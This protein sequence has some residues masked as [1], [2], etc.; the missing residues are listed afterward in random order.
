MKKILFSVAAFSMLLVSC[1]KD[2]NSSKVSHIPSTSSNNT[3]AS[4]FVD[5]EYIIQL[6]SGFFKTTGI[7]GS[8]AEYVSKIQKARKSLNNILLALP[9]GES[10]EVLNVYTTAINGFAAKLTDEQL[11]ALSTL[12][13]VIAI[14][15]NQ[16]GQL[17]G[18]AGNAEVQSQTEEYGVIRTGRRDGTGKRAFILDSGID[19]DHEDLNV[20]TDLGKDFTADGGLF[21]GGGGL[22]GGG[23][24]GGGLFG[25]GGEAGPEGDDDNGHGTHCAGIVAAL[26]NNVGVVG[27]APN[28]EV[29]AVKCFN[30]LGNGNS[31]DVIQ[32]IDYVAE[33]GEAGDAV[34]MSF[35]FLSSS[36]S[37]DNAVESLGTQGLYVAIAAGNDSRDATGVSPAGANGV[38]LYTVSAMDVNDVFASFSNYGSPV[39]YSAPGVDVY[40][41]YT[42]NGYSTLSGT[43]MA[44][45]HVAGLLLI[46]DGD[47]N[48]DGNVIGDPDGDADPIAHL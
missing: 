27:V 42:N 24:F 43:S 38:N 47:L 40:S 39:D 21:G 33:V 16:V 8:V 32:A 14:D 23:L 45:P 22:F 11:Q 34:N 6:E 1:S 2:T 10:I 46:T 9:D 18:V 17:I 35:S 12:T 4:Q 36:E 29:V 44:A 28:A 19:L 48:T 7:T 20:N 3:E 26:D 41:T 31:S 13:E 37:L 25:G 5:G 30:F 15:Q